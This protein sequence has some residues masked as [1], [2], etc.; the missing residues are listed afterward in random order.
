MHVLLAVLVAGATKSFS[1]LKT[2]AADLT[3]AT[4]ELAVGGGDWGAFKVEDLTASTGTKIV[5]NW[6]GGHNVVMTNED[7][8]TKCTLGDADSVCLATDA[9]SAT[10][11]CD[12]GNIV[13]PANG[14]YKYEAVM[15]SAG[16]YYFICAVQGHCGSQKVKV[17]VTE[18]ETYNV[19]QRVQVNWMGGG[20]WW[21]ARVTKVNSDNTYDVQYDSDDSFDAG[22]TIDNLRTEAPPPPNDNSCASWNLNDGVCDDGPYGMC[23]C[24]TDLNDC[25]YR[26][27]GDCGTTTTA[28][29]P[30]PSP[31]RNTNDCNYNYNGRCDDGGTGSRNSLCE[32]GTDRTDCGY[33]SAATCPAGARDATGQRGSNVGGDS[34]G[35]LEQCTY[36]DMDPSTVEDCSGNVNAAECVAV[37]DD[38][39][40]ECQAQANGGA[41]KGTCSGSSVK[42][43]FHAKTDCSDDT[44]ATCVMSDL[45]PGRLVT[46]TGC[47]MTYTIGECETFMALAGMSVRIKFKGSCPAVKSL[48][49]SSRS[50]VMY[51]LTGI[52]GL[53]G[54]TLIVL[55]VVS[56][57]TEK[58]K[59]PPNRTGTPNVDAPVG[60][61]PFGF[62]FPKSWVYVWWGYLAMV[63]LSGIVFP[64]ISKGLPLPSSNSETIET[65][66]IIGPFI[67]CILMPILWVHKHREDK[68]W[69]ENHLNEDVVVMT[70]LDP[71]AK[72]TIFSR[73]LACAKSCTVLLF[74][75]T[76][77]LVDLALRIIKY[78]T[79][80]TINLSAFW[81]PAPFYTFWKA[82][83][84]I[85][86]IQVDGA[87]ICTN[88]NQGDAYMKFCTEA[89]LN[90]WTLGIYGKCCGSRT[91]YGRWL[92]RH[93]LWQGAP[94]SGY[95][96]REL[97]P[98]ELAQTPSPPQTGAD[99]ATLVCP[100]SEF[101]IF[102]EKLSCCQKVKVYFFTLLLTLLGGFL[103][104]VPYAA[105]DQ[106]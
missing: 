27:S 80:G 22:V 8:W 47:S 26:F 53:F 49:D 10:G 25:G 28:A 11:D 89:M 84:Q 85:D 51:I 104:W 65:I 69:I 62:L 24:G 96:N 13:A 54:L 48:D 19:G 106:T 66:L 3:A 101:R 60:W 91:S 73:K 67:H 90:W 76:L 81:F 42:M 14:N 9:S 38:I 55:L 15:S 12:G 7:A 36:M 74:K 1:D 82:K 102:D 17:T 97:P 29:P 5:F 61:G 56:R 34:R 75:L 50:L 79:G 2:S 98:F 59:P 46:P 43:H 100:P 78:A 105:P 92:D 41:M 30:P 71:E 4:T 44:S 83:L 70:E 94:P 99:P 39:L 6:A 33:R 37:K 21:D 23:E 52:L 93:V 16:E 86:L 40:G 45:D 68:K 58:A 57:F 20:T 72:T 18:A 64:A 87:K 77:G 31:L 35:T 88:A 32:C 63:V 95:T 103:T